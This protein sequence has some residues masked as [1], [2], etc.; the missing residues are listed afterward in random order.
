MK[1]RQEVENNGNVRVINFWEDLSKHTSA[2]K[3]VAHLYSDGN[4]TY[5]FFGTVDSTIVDEVVKQ[6][7]QVQGG[8]KRPRNRGKGARKS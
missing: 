1:L 7:R 3:A 8:D 4:L 2:L 5:N 6:M